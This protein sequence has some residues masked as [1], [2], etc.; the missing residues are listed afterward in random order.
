MGY[1]Y[2]WVKSDPITSEQ[3]QRA[4]EARS[5]AFYTALKLVSR[6]VGVIPATASALWTRWR[7]RQA[8]L[9]SIRELSALSDRELKDIGIARGEI[10]HVAELSAD[11][12]REPREQVTASDAR[13]KAA[14]SRWPAWLRGIIEGGQTGSGR[15]AGQP[16]AAAHNQNRRKSA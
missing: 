3:L 2:I 16:T 11:G 9:A 7:K 13:R 15:T 5:A 8:R 4:N 12:V 14:T 10:Y 6:A 1:H